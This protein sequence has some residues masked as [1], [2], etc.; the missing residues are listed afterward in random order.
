MKTPRQQSG[1]VEVAETE[2][3]TVSL[4]RAPGKSNAFGLA[5]DVLIVALYV[6]AGKL[7]LLLALPP[8]YVSAIFPS[9]G[10]AVAYALIGGV[11]ALPAIFT[12]S[13][14]LNIWIS[15]SQGTD[16]TI[17]GA[18]IAGAIALAS[19]LQAGIGGACLKGIAG[20]PVRFD[21][22]R[23]IWL[24]LLSA[25]LVC[26]VSASL[27]VGALV[28]LGITPTKMFMVNWSTWWLGDTLGVIVFVPLTLV[29]AAEPRALWRQRRLAI[30]GTMLMAFAMCVLIYVTAA[31]WEKQQVLLDFHRQSQEAADQLQMHMRE[32]E[33]L[34]IQIAAFVTHS[35]S[36][37][38][39]A[40]DFRRFV[41]PTLDRFSI[42]Q[43][44][45]WAPQVPAAGR[46]ALE[47]R[48]RREYPGF[49]FNIEE[50]NAQEKMVVAGER[51]QYFPII[52]DEPSEPN[53]IAQGFDLLSNADRRAAI[54]TSLKT[55]EP[56]VTPP[57][58]LIRTAAAHQP[59]MLLMRY[60]DHGP[61]GPG[62]VASVLRV[63][64]FVNWALT[65]DRSQFE[66]CIRDVAAARVVYG[67][68]PDHQPLA[69]YEKTIRFGG[70]DFLVQA[71]PSAAYLSQ[72]HG[73]QSLALL[74][75]GL[76][77][78]GLLGALLLLGTGYAERA[79]NLVRERTAEL[80]RQSA[81]TTLFL[82]NSSDGIH[83]LDLRGTI[84]EASD[85]FCTMLGY[86][87]TEVI[88]MNLRRWDAGLTPSELERRL[89]QI[90]AGPGVVVFETRHRRKDGT[91][92]DV[93]V[94][95]RPIELEGANVVFASSRD[96][97]ER[98]AAEEK[99]LNLA[100]YDTLTGLPN[101]RLFL[102]RMGRAMSA[103]A[104]T[105]DFGALMM[106]DMDRFKNINDTLGHD[107]GDRLLVDVAGRIQHCVREETTVCRLGGDEFIVMVEGL[108]RD[109]EHAAGLSEQMAE[110]IRTHLGRPYELGDSDS[111]YRVT[112]SIGVTL[113]HGIDSSVDVLLKQA[114][115][116]MYQAKDAGRNAI[117][118]FSPAMQAAIDARIATEGAL[119]QALARGELRLYYQ[120]Q[121]DQDGRRIGAEALVRWQHPSRGLVL[122]G[123]FIPLAEETGL[124]VEVGQW[125]LDSACAQL[126]RWARDP[127]HEHLEIA[128]NISARQF[129]QKDFVERIR[130]SL[131]A[132]GARPTRL[133]LELTESVVL[134][135]V[136]E[137]VSRMAQLHGLGVRFSLDDFGTGYSSLS[138]LKRLP[139]DQIKIDQSFIRDIVV[140]PNDAAIVEAI[141]AMCRT[142]GLQ[143]IAEGVE[144]EAQRDFLVRNG[145]TAFQGYFFGRPAPIEEWTRLPVYA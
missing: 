4:A 114:D 60:V 37:P 54:I 11:R 137:V 144:T 128:V 72:H 93:E 10:I 121:T 134:A 9:A 26:L 98:K 119:R 19:A 34:V 48:M 118:F 88:G 14:L 52:F 82:R 56:A 46:A 44:V 2:S 51:A 79:E 63:P 24:F 76:L 28:G 112:T 78:T 5:D 97:S 84:L 103:G 58:T 49:V 20:Y 29:L 12:G 62:V 75:G 94:A 133:K 90:A 87:R 106:L 77:G 99:I 45:I 16:M 125:V 57:L 142:L 140:D 85:S 116:A 100:Y 43:A 61:N 47:A 127:A 22:N 136:E 111:D 3:A 27:S 145:C 25:P 96:I 13:L 31:R 42:V 64:D 95:T 71:V 86:T 53:R 21:K 18:G 105:R 138:Y 141:L 80:E 110:R 122:P 123:E 126:A 65:G 40:D 68:L 113:F 130:A 139:L 109:Q 1:E 135:N 115:V 143:V 104:R 70:R 41:T 59:G 107:V 33:H 81:K 8:G 36:R 50:R 17:Q 92:F 38:V 120:P 102:D 132:S 30:G 15:L 39:S 7:S 129:H 91:T 73:W 32:Q 67:G 124:I 108:G 131:A 89:A 101:R 6:A 83:I 23:E 66:V 35:E 117:R 69:L 55:G 74:A